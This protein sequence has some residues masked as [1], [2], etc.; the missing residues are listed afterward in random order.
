MA[1]SLFEFHPAECD[2][3]DDL[4]GKTEITLHIS[5]S[6]QERDMYEL[7]REKA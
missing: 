6:E 3:L 2:V 7:L 5:L 1:D 4:P